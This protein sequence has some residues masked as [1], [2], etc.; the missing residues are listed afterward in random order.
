MEPWLKTMKQRPLNWLG[1]LMSLDTN[2]PDAESPETVLN[3]HWGKQ[4][5]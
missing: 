1:H 4:G 5:F 2:T 3:G